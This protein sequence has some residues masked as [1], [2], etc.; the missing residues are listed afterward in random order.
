MPYLSYDPQVKKTRGY[1]RSWTKRPKCVVLLEKDSSAK[2]YGRTRELRSPST[3][4]GTGSRLHKL[5][6]RSWRIT[7]RIL[8]SADF[9][10]VP[11]A[12]F[13][14]L[15][16]SIILSHDRRRPVQFAVT[17]HPTVEW[18]AAL[19]GLPLGHSSALFVA[20]S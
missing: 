18:I 10:V 16:A 7:S 9:F 17:S 19:A 1:A 11:T 20:R 5:G 6:V 14:L 3:W 12:T 8:V 2:R 4:C 15:S 13:R